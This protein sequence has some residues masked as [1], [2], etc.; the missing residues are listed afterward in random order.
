MRI[1]IFHCFLLAGIGLWTGCEPAPNLPPAPK[2]V[3]D[4]LARSKA[5]AKG[6]E[7]TALP[8]KAGSERF[9]GLKSP[10][11]RIGGGVTVPAGDP[12][13]TMPA[14]PDTS[15]SSPQEMLQQA[16]QLIAATG[17]MTGPG[18][19]FLS[20]KGGLY[21]V[22]SKITLKNAQKQVIEVRLE[23]IT[24]DNYVLSAGGVKRTCKMLGVKSS[25]APR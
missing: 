19:Q 23:S 15:A 1:P 12:T 18:G 4:S 5:L 8:S 25:S 22:G 24:G 21:P 13:A 2:D 16:E 6:D 17:S 7:F 14:G 20:G 9:A 10:F 3:S 11:E